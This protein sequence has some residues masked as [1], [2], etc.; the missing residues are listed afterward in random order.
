M[1]KKDSKPVLIIIDDEP[2]FS[3]SLQMA[4]EDAYNISHAPSLSRARETLD[5]KHPDVILLD[6]KLPDGNGI[7][8]LRELRTMEPMPIVFVMTAHA[9]IDNAVASLKEG[10]VDYF[11]KPLDI[12]KLRREINIYIENRILHKKIDTLDMKIRRINP[13]FVTSGIN[14][15]KPIVDKVPM[16]APLNIPVLITGETGTGKEKLAGW[17]HELS[18]AAGDMVAINCSALPKD[19]F[20]NELFGHVKGA[21]SGAV[22]QK[23]GLVER[24]EN[25]TLFLD[26]I[27]ELPE[28]V[29]AKLLRVVEE[30]V[31]YK[32]GDSRERRISFRLIS[33]TSKDLGSHAGFRSD[34]FY[35]ING[36]TFGLPPLRERKEDIRLLVSTF[37]DEANR[38][39]N[40][41]VSGVSP[42]VMRQ[43]ADY[44]WP[45]NIRQLKWL[46]HHAV[47]LTS[48]DLLDA[49]DLSASS[50]IFK[51][52]PKAGGLDYSVPFQEALKDL[53][54]SYIGHA[55]LSA[56]NNRTEAAR[57]LGVSVRVLHYKI[58][59]YG[60]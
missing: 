53:E 14:A 42:K 13:P 26:E 5:K 34:L 37:I 4:L 15:M 50:D 24:A 36:I 30:G 7:G 51:D 47:A 27:G 6:I 59:K 21:F 32:I 22:L 17:I 41:N 49:D 43:F 1:G 39:Y 57:I 12:E 10:A 60:L 8:F 58:R 3:E 46:I 45:G 9:T 40:K 56:D 35:R 28:S 23:E 20:E 11:T 31:Y 33:A 19:I 16:I 25:G 44:C 52:G 55:L 18:G 54:K 2:H 48:R 38:A 29:Q